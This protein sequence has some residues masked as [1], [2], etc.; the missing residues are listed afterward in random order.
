M[1]FLRK[2]KEMTSRK[3]R[4]KKLLRK[5]RSSWKFS[6][7]HFPGVEETPNLSFSWFVWNSHQKQQ[8]NKGLVSII[9]HVF[10]D[11]KQNKKQKEER[12]EVYKLERVARGNFPWSISQ[13]TK[14]LHWKRLKDRFV[15]P[16]T[17]ETKV[18]RATMGGRVERKRSRSFRAPATW[19][20]LIKSERSR[21]SQG[22]LFFEAGNSFEIAQP[23][24]FDNNHRFPALDCPVFQARYSLVETNSRCSL[25]LPL[26]FSSRVF[27]R[28]LRKF[29]SFF[30][31]GERFVKFFFFESLRTCEDNSAA[32]L[33][34]VRKLSCI[35]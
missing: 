7:E 5:I 20:S 22:G 6:I 14:K 28:L 21:I 29:L 1:Y 3:R 9:Y 18:V 24:V 8:R 35:R 2:G 32:T 4:R 17:K 30:R 25:F 12:E 26:F 16:A 19:R 31:R 15:G 33:I 23:F 13:G 27:S 34:R 11:Q 10:L